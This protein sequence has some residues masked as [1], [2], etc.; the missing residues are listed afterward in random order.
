MDNPA[1]TEAT[2]TPQERAVAALSHAAILL[3][4]AGAALPLLAAI[5]FGRGRRFVRFQAAQALVYH[6]VNWLPLTLAP[7]IL[8]APMLAA[9]FAA[10][11]PGGSDQESLTTIFG[12]LFMTIWFLAAAAAPFLVAWCLIFCGVGLYAAWR[13]GQG[14]EFR[15]PLLGA[16]LAAIEARRAG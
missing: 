4:L 10:R 6:L 5:V 1:F 3:P 11:L 9:W 14:K 7:L 13:A 15:Y 8:F 2:P 16:W 12:L